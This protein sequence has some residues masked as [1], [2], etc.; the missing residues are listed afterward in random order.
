MD[1]ALD[2]DGPAVH[3]LYEPICEW[4]VS[5]KKKGIKI[6]GIT[7]VTIDN[8]HY[9]KMLMEVGELR[10]L[11]GVRTNFGIADGKQ[12]DFMVYHENQ[13]QYLKLF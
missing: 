13:I 3:V 7:E 10:H 12:V 8:I 6:R 5:L 4:L 9:C 11:D 1:G 2:K